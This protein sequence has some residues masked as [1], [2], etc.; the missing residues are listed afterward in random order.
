MQSGYFQDGNNHFTSDI[1]KMRPFLIK[2]MSIV[3]ESLSSYNDREG[4]F[5]LLV[6][7]KIK[8]MT[9]KENHVQQKKTR[10]NI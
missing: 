10:A 5:T 7:Y 4:F 9:R 6:R 2:S 3:L 1:D 8:R